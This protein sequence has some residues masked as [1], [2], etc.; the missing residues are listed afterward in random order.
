M[1]KEINFVLNGSEVTVA[2]EAHKRL[3][4]VLRGPLGL[5]GTKEGCG[6]GE[7]GACTVIVDGRAVNSCLYPALEVEGKSV[8]T[9]EG[10]LGTD[11]NLSII[12]EAF[13]D[14][15]GIQCGFCTPG[16]IMSTKALL[17]DNPDPTEEEIR[18]ALLGNLCRCT[19]YV[20]II[21]SVKSAAD[22]VKNQ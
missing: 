19:G 17:D 16:M 10:L 6:E 3:I 7:C 14:Q 22:M 8:T 11:N 4:D 18:D 9:I 21:E 20:Q 12:Q 2:I 5:T 1:K 15:G 13:V